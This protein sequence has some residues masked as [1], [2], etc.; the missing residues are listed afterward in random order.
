MELDEMKLAWQQLNQR[1]DRQQALNL[2]LY[3]E[4]RLDKLRHG[5]RPLVWG[6]AIQIAFGVLFMLLGTAYWAGHLETLHRIVLGVTVQVFGIVMVA[7]A[8]RILHLVL[9]I[10]YTAPVLDIQ[11]RLAQL[12]AWRVRIEAPVFAVVGSF[13]WIPLLLMEIHWEI[14]VD[15]WARWPAFVGWLVICGWIS[16]ALVLMVV[17][18]AHWTGRMRWITDNAAGK[19][20]RKAEAALEEIACFERDG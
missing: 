2:R 8:G 15:V 3:R 5:L 6:Q 19:A 14:G 10:D 1:L 12:R 18:L 4:R 13:V 17:L 7:F 11:R 16:L 9:E 20:V